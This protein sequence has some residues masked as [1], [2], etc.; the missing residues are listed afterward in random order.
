MSSA[1]ICT[2]NAVLFRISLSSCSLLLSSHPLLH[3]K[4]KHIS[5]ADRILDYMQTVIVCIYG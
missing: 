4:S 5:L 2:F 3:V 1:A